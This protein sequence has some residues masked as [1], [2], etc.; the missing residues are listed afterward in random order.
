MVIQLPSSGRANPAVRQFSERVN[1]RRGQ[2]LEQNYTV[3]DQFF[4]K[5]QFRIGPIQA[6]VNFP[7]GANYRSGSILELNYIG[8]CQ[9]RSNSRVRQFRNWAVSRAGSIP[10][11]GNFTTDPKEL[12]MDRLIASELGD[13]KRKPN[14]RGPKVPTPI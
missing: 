2:S 13:P 5:G 10:S 11:R 7:D 8:S 12:G 14:Q 9:L 3:S 4:G 6:R 1:F